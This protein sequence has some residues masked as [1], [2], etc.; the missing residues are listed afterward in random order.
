MSLSFYLSPMG[1]QSSKELHPSFLL[2]MIK[3]LW[4]GV[5]WNGLD[6]NGMEWRRVL[7][8]KS[9]IMVKR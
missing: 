8:S 6:W 9:Q 7:F 1:R 2:Y 4:S 5:E 3:A